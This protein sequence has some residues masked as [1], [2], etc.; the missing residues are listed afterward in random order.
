MSVFKKLFSYFPGFG[1]CCAYIP[2]H[3]LSGMYYDKNRSLATG[4][5]TSGSGLG[6]AVMPVV[7]GLLIEIY[8]WKGSLVVVA[9]LCLHMFIFS[10]LLRMPEPNAVSDQAG[11][12][13]NDNMTTPMLPDQKSLESQGNAPS[14]TTKPLKSLDLGEAGTDGESKPLISEV[15]KSVPASNLPLVL[16]RDRGKFSDRDKPSEPEY[17][18]MGKSSVTSKEHYILPTEMSSLKATSP[19]SDPQSELKGKGYADILVSK[20]PLKTRLFKPS[21]GLNGKSD[22]FSLEDLSG[23]SRSHTVMVTSD[24]D[25]GNRQAHLRGGSKS[26]DNNLSSNGWRLSHSLSSLHTVGTTRGSYYIV[27][28]KA[29]DVSATNQTHHTMLKDSDT[30]LEEKAEKSEGG[31]AGVQKKKKGPNS[32]RHIYIFTHYGFNIYFFSNIMWNAGCS[33]VTSFAPEFLRSQ[34]LTSMEAAVLLGAFGFGCFVGGI[35]GGLLGNVSCIN[36]QVLYTLANIIMGA[37]LIV[38]PSMGHRDLYLT[39]LLVS[40]LAFGII[41]GL[42]IIVLTDLIGVESLSN[43]LGYLML[44]NG[45]GTFLGPPLAG[46]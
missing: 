13:P 24:T 22:A 15:S 2:S 18:K 6:G 11:E 42:L 40:G 41:L 27:L 33:I 31:E 1:S 29:D 26:T 38:F 20:D 30:H 16:E 36:R 45:I 17:M 19:V 8:S 46:K 43:G 14:Q 35:F 10:A 34:G 25:Q 37:V 12:D 3:V 39:A 28:D 32:S 5:A 44:S 9:A 7:A 23:R 4:V 21:S